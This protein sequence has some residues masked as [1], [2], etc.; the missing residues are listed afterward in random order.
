MSWA[1]GPDGTEYAMVSGDQWLELYVAMRDGDED[2]AIGLLLEVKP[3]HWPL[4]DERLDEDPLEAGE[5]R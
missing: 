5:S 1:M 4:L 3:S 2:R